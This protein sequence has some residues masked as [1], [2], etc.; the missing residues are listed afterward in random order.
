ME[1]PRYLAGDF[2]HDVDNI[3]VL[4]RLEAMHFVEVQ[5]LWHMRSGIAPVA[6]CKGRTRRDLLYVSHELAAMLVGVKVDPLKWADHA[7]V[8]ATFRGTGDAIRRYPWPLPRPLPWHLVRSQPVVPCFQFEFPTDCTEAYKQFWQSVEDRVVADLDT[9]GQKMSSQCFGR[10]QRLER[11]VVVGCRAPP[12]KGRE[13]EFQPR[14][15]GLSFVH[16]QWLKQLRRLQ[17]YT[18]LCGVSATSWAHVEHRLSLWNSSFVHLDLQR[19][20]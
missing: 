8:I 16:A 14:F 13:G 10:A 15:F 9:H 19:I 1:G 12:K 4:Q 17:S 2:N 3:P 18:R 20:W 7:E 5:D 11:H 6:T